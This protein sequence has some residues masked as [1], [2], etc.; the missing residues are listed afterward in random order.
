M[1]ARL[2]RVLESADAELTVPQYR[3]LSA[4][5]EGGLRS[6]R[7]AER[8]AVRKPTVTALADAMI[9]AGY[10]ARESEAGDRRIV[11]LSLTEAG[12]EAL[13]RADAA[14]LARLEPLLAGV[15]DQ[16]AFLG[17][18]RAVGEALDARLARAER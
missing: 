17:S 18:L 8:L 9:A 4:L 2:S 5:S 7:L 3:M 16:E 12:Q 14:Y 1:L 15:P 11:R 6:A 10:V 13:E